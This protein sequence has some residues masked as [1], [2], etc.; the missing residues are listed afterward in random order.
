M[1]RHVHGS[2]FLRPG[3]SSNQPF[4]DLRFSALGVRNLQSVSAGQI[5][6]PLYVENF[7]SLETFCGRI[8]TMCSDAGRL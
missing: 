8:Q 4:I 6:V 7:H 2:N 3:S 5:S 1:T